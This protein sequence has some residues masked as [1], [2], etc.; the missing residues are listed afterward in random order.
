MTKQINTATHITL[1]H[2]TLHNTDI[3]QINST[4]LDNNYFKRLYHS[5]QT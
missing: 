2:I 4:L 1:K 3:K 5:I